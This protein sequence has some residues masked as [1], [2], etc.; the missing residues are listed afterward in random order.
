MGV[1]DASF[2]FGAAYV[3]FNVGVHY[4]KHVDSHPRFYAYLAN[5]TVLVTVNLSAGYALIKCVAA[6]ISST[7]KFWA[8]YSVQSQDFGNQIGL[9]ET[10]SILGYLAWIGALSYGGN[11]MASIMWLNIDKAPANF[12][13]LQGYKYMTVGLLISAGSWISALALGEQANNLLAIFD[14]YAYVNNASALFIDMGIHGVMEVFNL[15]VLTTIAGLGF[16]VAIFILGADLDYLGDD[17]PRLT[18]AESAL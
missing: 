5:F 15:I 3:L 6:V 2:L 4:F 11:Y 7:G 8:S 16:V 14:T 10:L 18:A 9:A 17:M 1:W 12:T 13:A